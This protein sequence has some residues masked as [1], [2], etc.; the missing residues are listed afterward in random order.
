M[1]YTVVHLVAT[2]LNDS[3]EFRQIT[4]PIQLF[5]SVDPELHG[6]SRKIL[7]TVDSTLLRYSTYIEVSANC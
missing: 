1:I 3:V 5:D 4:L 2:V 6:S 7:I